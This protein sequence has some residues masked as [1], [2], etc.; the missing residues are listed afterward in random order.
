MD[1]QEN[2]QAA[3][4][5]KENEIKDKSKSMLDAFFNYFTF[6]Y[7][8]K[9]SFSTSPVSRNYH[10]ELQTQ[11]KQAYIN[12][13]CALGNSRKTWSA[14][15][16]LN[17]CTN[18]NFILPPHLQDPNIINN[19]FASYIQSVSDN[20]NAKINFYEN[21]CFNSNLNFHFNLTTIEEVNK[22]L[23]ILKSNARGADGIIICMLKY[24]RP[25]IDKY[26]VHIVNCCIEANYF[27]VIW[28]ESIGK[29][30]PKKN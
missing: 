16:D 9:T 24:C 11:E 26:L 30:L 18:H 15:K 6:N 20:C 19:H 22:I 23:N 8:V 28:K 10:G 25:F 3:V 21:N 12:S 4:Y 14:L 5:F 1:F 7:L 29:V 27:P 13:V 17:V 2:A